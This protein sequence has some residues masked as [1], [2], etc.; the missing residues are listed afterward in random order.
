MVLYIHGFGGSG[1]GSKATVLKPLFAPQSFL[2]PSLS[3]VPKLAMDTL[4]EMIRACQQYE[5]V[6]LIG[7]SLGGYY[8]TYLACKFDLPAVLINPATKPEV[9]LA[10]ALGLAPNFY[11]GSTFAWTKEH[12]AMLGKYHITTQ[13]EKRFLVLL[14]KGDEL[15]DYQKAVQTYPAATVNIEEGGSHSFEG[16]EHHK[17]AMMNFFEA[18]EKQS[19]R[20][21]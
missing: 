16:I 2:A 19:F 3:Y 15:L 7:S 12:L 13:N 9:T 17:A 14:Q 8:A 10:R 21:I 4:E 6:F 20:L 5:P 1:K 11:D 18:F